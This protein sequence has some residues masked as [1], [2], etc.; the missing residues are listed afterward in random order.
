MEKFITLQ[1]PN[2]VI[3]KDNASDN[4]LSFIISSAKNNQVS[5]ND[6]YKLIPSIYSFCYHKKQEDGIHLGEIEFKEDD[7]YSSD[8]SVAAFS[9][10]NEV[11]FCP[12]ITKDNSTMINVFDLIDSTF[13]EINHV[14]EFSNDSLRSNTHEFHDSHFGSIQEDAIN[15]YLALCQRHIGQDDIFKC[16]NDFNLFDFL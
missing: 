2:N 16:P 4:I 1:R 15:I 8:D 11:H 10:A 13:H 7:K 5:K 3:D 9:F 14:S 6:F 12:H